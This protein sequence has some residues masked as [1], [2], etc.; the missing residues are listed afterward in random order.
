MPPSRERNLTLSSLWRTTWYHKPI[1]KFI[2]TITV[3]ILQ[4]R[5]DVGFHGSNQIPTPNIDALAYNGIILDKF[6]TQY[7]CTPSRAALLTGNYPL[8]YGIHGSP[9][10]AGQNRSL[11]E[12]VTTMP[13]HLKKLGYKTHL[14]GKWHLGAA[15]KKNTPLRRGFDTHFGYW[16]GFVGYF[17]YTAIYELTNETVSGS[18]ADFYH[19]GTFTECERVGCA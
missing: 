10:R 5:N 12:D 8:R 18:F 7:A 19:N 1:L 9:I 2:V 17:D 16:H 14:V 4:G 13:E 3:T 15:Y 6:Y 11:P